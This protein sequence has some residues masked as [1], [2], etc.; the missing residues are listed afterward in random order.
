MLTHDFVLFH[1]DASGDLTTI[2][3]SDL[4]LMRL[5]PLIVFAQVRLLAT[6]SAKA[7]TNSLF[8]FSSTRL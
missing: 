1:P 5:T 2:V 8:F 4:H 7:T 6:A 3:R